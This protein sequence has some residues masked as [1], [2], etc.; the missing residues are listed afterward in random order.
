MV[1]L[2]SV[3]Q[4]HLGRRVLWLLVAGWGVYVLD[5]EGNL[6]TMFNSSTPLPGID[7]GLQLLGVS[8]APPLAV[9]SSASTTSPGAACWK[10]RPTTSRASACFTKPRACPKGVRRGSQRRPGHGVPTFMESSL[11]RSG[12]RSDGVGRRRNVPIGGG[13]R[14]SNRTLSIDLKTLAVGVVECETRGFAG[15]GAMFSREGHLLHASSSVYHFAQQ[16]GQLAAPAKLFDMHPLPLF[17]SARAPRRLAV[18]ARQRLAANSPGRLRRWRNTYSPGQPVLPGPYNN[19]RI[20]VSAQ[21]GLIG[22]RSHL[23]PNETGKPVLYQVSI[24][25]ST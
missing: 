18:R 24:A 1:P 19:L 23:Y 5:A 3:L 8:P 17:S 25:N 11:P 4:R 6:L 22:F 10:C 20:G 16:R 21:Y 12:R 14:L 15:N 13:V 9:G 2:R 7:H